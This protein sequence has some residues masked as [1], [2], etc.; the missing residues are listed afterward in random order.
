[1]AR[2]AGGRDPL[3]RRGSVDLVTAKPTSPQSDVVAKPSPAPKPQFRALFEQELGYVYRSLKRLGCRPGD[4]EDLAQEIFVAV[5]AKLDTFD[6]SRPLR[7]WL[8][9][10]VARS[11]ANYRRLARHRRERFD[12]VEVAENAASPESAALQ[13]ETR[14]LLMEALESVPFERRTALI[15]HDIDGFEAKEIADALTI[16]V[17]TVY[18]RVRLARDDLKK[19]VRRLRARLGESEVSD[20][21]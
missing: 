20:G 21:L 15:M 19:A 11:A 10:F 12:D 3:A 9:G 13:N 14:D 7:P 2:L 4:V 6:P 8:F 17:N 5:Y 18:S 1:V 16:P